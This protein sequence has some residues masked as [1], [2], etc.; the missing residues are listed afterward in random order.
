MNIRILRQKTKAMQSD[1][2]FH[3]DK[4]QVQHVFNSLTTKG[5]AGMK[6][7][8][9]SDWKDVEIV[10]AELSDAHER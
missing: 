8:K 6:I 7:Q 3:I 2:Q 5:I 10:V 9:L 4:L 1:G